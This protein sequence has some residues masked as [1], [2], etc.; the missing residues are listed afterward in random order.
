LQLE[1]WQISVEFIGTYLAAILGPFGP[2][3][4]EKILKNVLP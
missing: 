3:I 1:D 4:A 2:L